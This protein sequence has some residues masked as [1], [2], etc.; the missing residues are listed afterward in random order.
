MSDACFACLTPSLCSLSPPLR[1]QFHSP[2]AFLKM[3]ATQA[4]LQCKICAHFCDFISHRIKEYLN[5][6]SNN[7]MW[8]PGQMDPTLLNPTL[9]DEVA[10]ECNMLDSTLGL[11]RSR[12]ETY[13]ES[14]QNK[15]VPYWFAS[16]LGA[17]DRLWRG[18]L[19]LL[20]CLKC[21]KVDTVTKRGKTRHWIKQRG[22]RLDKAK[23]RKGI[24]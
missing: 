24:F 20:L 23:G 7:Y 11:E 8:R 13:P 5:E 12:S 19:L 6:R 17:I 18:V 10:N 4:T 22:E 1:L 14:L 15:R 21:W 2:C 9:L 3:P 16:K